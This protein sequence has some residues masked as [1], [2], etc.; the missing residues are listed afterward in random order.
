RAKPGLEALQLRV[1]LARRMNRTR[2]E[3][4]L[5]ERAKEAEHVGEVV[6]A[7]ETERLELVVRKWPVRDRL[8]ERAA[9]R[10]RHLLAREVL[11]GEPDAPARQRG[12]AAEHAVGAFADVLRG[13]A[14]EPAVG[15]RQG[16]HEVSIL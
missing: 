16:E 1:Q 3:E 7:R 9:E 12:P 11:A 6:R 4:R 13:D 14:G 8:S 10:G 15:H 2:A 5:L